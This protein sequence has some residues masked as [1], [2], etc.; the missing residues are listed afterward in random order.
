MIE[1]K[2]MIDYIEQHKEVLEQYS[3]DV[4]I[5]HIIALEKHELTE[6]KRLDTLDCYVGNV[7]CNFTDRR[8]ISYKE[9]K[10]IKHEI[11]KILYD[12]L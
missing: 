8:L 5:D 3:K 11:S 9:Y 6:S 2:I 4:L 10:D 1:S 7:L 12:D